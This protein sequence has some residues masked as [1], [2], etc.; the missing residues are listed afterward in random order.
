MHALP[1]LA[2]SDLVGQAGGHVW[3][4]VTHRVAL[5]QCPPM[6]LRLLLKSILDF[7]M[8]RATPLD[9]SHM[10]A[11]NVQAI[12]LLSTRRS[13][14]HTMDNRKRGNYEHVGQTQHSTSSPPP[15]PNKPAWQP[16]NLQTIRKFP[17]KT[18]L[19]P[20]CGGSTTT[21]VLV[22]P[23]TTHHPHTTILIATATTSLNLALDINNNC[24]VKEEVTTASATT[25]K[26]GE[27]KVTCG[28]AQRWRSR[29]QQNFD[30]AQ[31]RAHRKRQC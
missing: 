25:I 16:E 26:A 10:V 14:A 7:P 28:N 13:R 19:W 21:S 6:T 11:Q 3:L 23:L 30:D 20:T 1:V 31:R 2:S 27:K 5:A 12:A 8:M 29:V 9:G 18:S 4:K 22:P 15:P 17:R 24:V